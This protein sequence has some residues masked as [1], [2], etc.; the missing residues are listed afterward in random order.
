MHHQPPH[1]KHSSVKAGEANPPMQFFLLPLDLRQTSVGGLQN[2]T[3]S[4]TAFI[5]E[6]QTSL[7]QIFTFL[8][9]ML[10]PLYSW[11]DT[12]FSGASQACPLAT[13]ALPL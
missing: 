7:E 2:Y 10:V 11:A 8:P 4:S 5:A 13:T 6:K 12:I 9:S 3:Y 1:Q